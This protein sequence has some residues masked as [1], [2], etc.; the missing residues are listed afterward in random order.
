MPDR[1]EERMSDTRETVGMLEG[2]ATARSIHRYRFDPIPD[3]DLAKILY[4]ATRAPSG[5]NR[6]PFRFVVLRDGERACRAK[7]LLGESF[8]SGWG[9]KAGSEGWQKRS[10]SGRSTRRIRSMAAMQH[11]VDNFE[12]IPVVVLACLVRFREPHHGEGAS[13]FPACQNLLLAARALGYGACFS[14]WHH[15]VEAELKELLGIPEEVVLSLT[16]TVGRP[17]GRHG[18]VRRFPVQELVFDDG[19]ECPATWVSD[20]P[21]ARLSRSRMKVAPV[22]GSGD[23]GDEGSAADEG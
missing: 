16:I 12:R 4:A 20:P 22:V 23:A 14:G 13:I 2:I 10:D 1:T 5:T 21:D 17:E 9:H 3:E 6:Q 8:R 11:F 7:A 15:A 18:P 19:W